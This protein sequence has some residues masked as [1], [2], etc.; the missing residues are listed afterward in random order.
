MA[1]SDR[2]GDREISIWFRGTRE[3]PYK[4]NSGVARNDR[5]TF[6]GFL[7][8]CLRLGMITVALRYLWEKIQKV[9]EYKSYEKKTL[10]TALRRHV[11][12]SRFGNSWSGGARH[13]SKRQSEGYTIDSPLSRRSP[14]G[15]V[16]PWRNQF[17]VVC[18]FPRTRPG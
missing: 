14:K 10:L 16:I 7:A 12:M 9:R 18:P 8:F 6:V 17:V 5:M 15:Q 1:S 11:W 2:T 3:K 13:G 4:R